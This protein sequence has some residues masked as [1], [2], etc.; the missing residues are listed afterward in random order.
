MVAVMKWDSADDWQKAITVYGKEVMGDIKN[1]SSES[2]IMLV[3]EAISAT[4]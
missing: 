2:P 1:F 3:G 4:S